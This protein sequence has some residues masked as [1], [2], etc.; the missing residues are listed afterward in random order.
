[1]PRFANLS[2]EEVSDLWTTVHAISPVLQ[3]YFNA[4]GLQLAIQDGP[5]AGQTVPHVHCHIV[6][7]RPGDFKKN[8]DVYD[9]LDNS[10][11]TRKGVDAEDRSPRTKAEMAEEAMALRQLFV[12]LSLPIPSASD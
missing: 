10:D 5:V 7:R 4:E 1:M 2:P 3:R 11:M 6:P 12:G 8:D 9:A